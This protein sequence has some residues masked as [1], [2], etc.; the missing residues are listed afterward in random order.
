MVYPPLLQSQSGCRS[1]RWTGRRFSTGLICSCQHSVQ[2]Q[3]DFTFML[4]RISLPTF[5]ITVPQALLMLFREK[6]VF[7]LL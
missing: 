6:P 4:Q 7:R 5:S 1:Q 3:A 2:N